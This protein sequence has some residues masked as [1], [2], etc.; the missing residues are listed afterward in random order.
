MDGTEVKLESPSNCRIINVKM[1]NARVFKFVFACLFAVGLSSVVSTKTVFAVDCSALN[2]GDCVP[3]GCVWHPRLTPHCSDQP[4]GCADLDPMQ[5]GT[6]TS[7]GCHLNTATGVCSGTLTPPIPKP[8]PVG[9][10]TPCDNSGKS[11]L[12]LIQCFK[13]NATQSVGDVYTQPAVL[14]NL[15]VKIIFIV[16]GIILF[17]MVIYSGFLFIT[18]GTKGMEEAQKVMLSAV[19][20]LIIVFCAF[21]IVQIIKLVTGADIGF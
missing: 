1:K 8:A 2:L 7:P 14:V 21:W 18:G 3:G 10:S 11:G 20:G 12:N 19:T 5:C 15:V 13:L 9:P 6:A 16:S 4:M 17:F